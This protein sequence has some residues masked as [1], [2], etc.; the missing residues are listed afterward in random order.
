MFVYVYLA[1]VITAELNGVN[2]KYYK[3]NNA[4]PFITFFKIIINNLIYK[5]VIFIYYLYR[6]KD[7]SLRQYIKG[8]TKVK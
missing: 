6:T 3:I 1:N 2:T 8:Y 7:I 4:V 5:K